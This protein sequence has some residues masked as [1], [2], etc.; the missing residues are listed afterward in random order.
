MKVINRTKETKRKL[1]ELPDELKFKMLM[2]YSQ[3]VQV[4]ELAK[5]YGI[6]PSSL[7]SYLGTTIDT[8]A[9]VKEANAIVSDGGGRIQT[10][11]P[12]VIMTEEWFACA[13][14]S[15][16]AYAFF[17]A[18]TGSSIFALEQAGLKD[19]YLPLGCKDGAKKHIQSARGK[20]LR[21]QPYISKQIKEY[22]EQKLKDANIDKTYVQSELLLQLDEL[23]ELSDGSER[24]RGH[25]LK[26]IELLGRTESA[27]VDTL[28]I[29]DASAKNSVDLLMEKI[30]NQGGS[31]V[32]V[33][34]EEDE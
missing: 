2:S 26:V 34:E 33:H 22:R 7:S 32:Y 30:K 18:T 10:G 23:K 17:F 12:T 13:E 14:E 29:E 1:A 19:N 27:F 8:L 31:D 4:K 24:S 11:T 21:D 6:N 9:V 28:K 25:L 5:E 15:A 3:G 20:W 16:D